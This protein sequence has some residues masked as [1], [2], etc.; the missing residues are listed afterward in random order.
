MDALVINNSLDDGWDAPDMSIS[1]RQGWSASKNSSSI[2]EPVSLPETSKLTGQFDVD[3]KNVLVFDDLISTG[4]TMVEAFHRLKKQGAKKVQ[5]A[6]VHGVLDEGVQW[7]RDASD[8]SIS[9]TLS[10]TK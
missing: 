10:Q 1:S 9:R 4:R 3:G 8:S 7:V 2:C 6:A 5:A